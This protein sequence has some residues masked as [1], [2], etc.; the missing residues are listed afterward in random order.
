MS[1]GFTFG[2]NEIFNNGQCQRCV[3]VCVVWAISEYFYTGIGVFVFDEHCSRVC[4]K[5]I[6]MYRQQKAITTGY[7][8]V[9]QSKVISNVYFFSFICLLVFVYLCV[10]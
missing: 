7:W 10:E 2:V 5:Q 3:C 4:E 6:K 9:D 1:T 8:I